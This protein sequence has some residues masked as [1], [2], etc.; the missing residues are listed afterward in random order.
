MSLGRELGAW[1]DL[2]HI[3]GLVAA[4]RLRMGDLTAARA[5][6]EAAEREE[7]ERGAFQSD[8]AVWFGL[9]QAE[10][11]VREGDA[12]AI[13]RQC[14]KVLSWLERKQSAWWQGFRGQ[15]QAR[16]ALAVLADG[17]HARCRAVLAAAL[18]DAS[19]W[20]ELP[21]LADV[22]DAI[23]V[24]AVQCLPG[25]TTPHV[26]PARAGRP[27]AECAAIL[28]GA[29]H[30]IR[31]CFDESSLDAPAARDAARARLGQDEF[32]AAYERGRAIARDDALALAAQTVA[33][34][35]A[36]G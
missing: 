4:V 31:G 26:P 10:L 36:P 33:D 7:S 32:G 19:D 17:E 3:G 5:E 16:L 13:A 35:A 30:S 1:G 12:A 23:A 18:R 25:G 9:I 24:L 21:P 27:G 6:L 34:P 14:E 20:V 8:S 2:I 15:V 11:Y 29:A 22:L 28:L